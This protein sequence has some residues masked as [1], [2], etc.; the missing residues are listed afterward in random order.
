[1]SIG[2][3]RVVLMVLVA[4]VAELV[5]DRADRASSGHGFGTSLSEAIE[6]EVDVYAFLFHQLG[7]VSPPVT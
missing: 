7:R 5:G 3:I 4:A 6:Q 2:T 1:M